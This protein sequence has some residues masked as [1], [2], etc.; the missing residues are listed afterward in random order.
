MGKKKI[1]VVDDEMIMRESI[2]EALLSGGYDVTVADNGLKAKEIIQKQDFDVVISDIKMPEL[3]GLELLR[4]VK[5]VSPDTLVILMTAFGTI[6]TAIEAMRYGAFDYLTKPF[7]IDALEVVLKKAFIHLEI[8]MEN[9]YLRTSLDE[10]FDLSSFIGESKCMKSV[11]DIIRKVANS[12]ATVL[13]RGESGTGKELVARS[14][15]YASPRKHKPFIKVNC[16]ALSAGLLESELFGHEKGAFTG[17]LSRKIGRFEMADGGTILLDEVSEIDINLQAKLLR[18]L[19]EREFE[20]VGGG[21]S[22]EV[23]V[24][25]I[26]TTNRNLEKSVKDGKFREDLFYR[27]NVVPVCLPSLRERKSDISLLMD[28]FLAK[29]AVENNKKLR[30]FEDGVADLLKTYEW[31]GNVREL[32]NAV[33]RA[34]VLSGGELLLKEHFEMWLPKTSFSAAEKGAVS[35]SAAEGYESGKTLA[36]I[37]R[38]YILQSLK[39]N[40]GNKTR[41]ARQLDISVRTLRNKLDEYKKKDLLSV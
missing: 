38:E 2:Q 28:S 12:K 17:A 25:I 31:P 40:E 16:A 18:V 20:R 1:L 13:V 29:Y 9:R 35:D 21:N 7:S 34:V 30:G 3:T 36:D 19:Q 37:E 23:D 15:H 6:E 33:E 10:K 39:E 22:I 26:A 4:Y 24:R 41:T 32:E 27:L 5:G 11:F 14:I 8:L